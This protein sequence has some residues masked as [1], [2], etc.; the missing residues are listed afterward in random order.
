MSA[1]KR[2]AVI[3]LVGPA[4][5]G[6]T[7]L[8]EQLEASGQ[9][10]RGTIWLVPKPVLL[11]GTLRQLP[12]ALTLYRETGKFL[13]KEIKHLA[14]LDALHTFV[15]T[16][17]WNGTRLVVLDEG[18]VYTLSWLQ[19]LGHRRFVYGRPAAFLRR[20]LER[21]ARSLDAIVMLDAPDEVLISR[22]RGRKKPHLM[23]GRSA[24]EISAFI[25]AYR[26]ATDHVVN[27]LRAI[28]GPPVVRLCCADDSDAL[29]ERL[30]EA[31][32]QHAHAR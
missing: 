32:E 6:K 28:G 8:S 22:I 27:D 2:P 13:W 10:A 23:K 3:E 19:V 1:R 25:R 15:R 17:H 21:W 7:T 16:T 9:A 30:L 20:T 11:H 12:T 14:R 29:A 18:P 5:V 31:L 26:L 24:L 4:G